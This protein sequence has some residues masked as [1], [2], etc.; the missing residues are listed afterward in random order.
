MPLPFAING[1]GRVGR[2]LLRIAHQRPE[3]ELV[4]VNDLEPAPALAR[5]LARDSVHGVFPEVL[6][7]VGDGLQIG[8]RTIPVLSGSRPGEIPWT[9]TGARV[10]VEATGRFV[11]RRAA[12]GHLGEP[13]RWVVVAANA[14]D[15]D[16]T[17]CRGVAE[18]DDLQPD[19]V[20]SNASCTTNALAPILRV[21][22]E[23]FGVSRATM[24]AVHSAT[25]NQRLLDGAH[26]EPRRGRA[27]PMNIIPV[28]TTTPEA[29][30]RLL[31]SLA[32]RIGG[33]AVRVPTPG[34]AMLEVTAELATEAV[35]HA[36]RKACGGDLA[37]TL[38]A[39][40]DELV[41]SDFIGCPCSAVVDLPLT[42]VV[43][44]RLVR[45][46]A[47]YDN[48]WGYA[49]RLADLLARI[50]EGTHSPA[51]AQPTGGNR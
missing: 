5:L 23:A 14:P 38:S 29:V 11:E 9:A 31:P 44:G 39:T 47:W 26:P 34:A 27:A 43:E 13:V 8:T 24:C 12:A 4:A 17:V 25:P 33:L 45:L 51:R 40:E 41:S 35:R 37:G 22:E 6:R 19:Q 1:L 20:V 48:E 49:S 10:V 3:L 50:A 28:A 46:V 15:A 42:E 21:L 30:G 2:A 32:G 18:I 16:R 36:F 7:A